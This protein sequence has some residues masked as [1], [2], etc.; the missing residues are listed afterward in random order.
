[1]ERLARLLRRLPAPPDAWVRAAQELPTARRE[2]DEIVTR[3][4]ADAAYRAQ[5]VMDLEAA[6]EAA[7]LEP[8]PALRAALRARLSA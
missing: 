8:E 4:E 6:L 1:M 5:V 2:L 3:C 7:G